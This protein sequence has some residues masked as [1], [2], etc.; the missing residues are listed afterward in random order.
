MLSVCPNEN[1]IA[2][3]KQR[4]ATKSFHKFVVLASTVLTCTVCSLE[5]VRNSNKMNGNMYG[6]FVNIK[7]NFSPNFIQF[8]SPC[9]HSLTFCCCCCCYCWRC[10]NTHWYSLSRA[11]YRASIFAHL[12]HKFSTF[13][14]NEL[15]T[16]G[17]IFSVVVVVAA[18]TTT[19]THR[20]LA[21]KIS[22]MYYNRRCVRECVCVCFVRVLWVNSKLGSL[23]EYMNFLNKLFESHFK[24]LTTSSQFS[25]VDCLI[26]LCVMH[27]DVYIWLATCVVYHVLGCVCVHIGFLYDENRSQ[28]VKWARA[29][30]LAF[31]LRVHSL[32]N[33]CIYFC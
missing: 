24:H 33:L 25:W 4:L 9:T 10:P 14:L 16:K 7:L 2:L 12:C 3:R 27:W 15:W 11:Q 28:V 6:H 17:R 31:L 23:G 22:S 5:A 20:T 21:C 29:L 18:G 30:S 8:H 32:Q 1:C 19:M 26:F 13:Y